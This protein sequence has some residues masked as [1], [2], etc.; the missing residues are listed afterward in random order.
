MV[1]FVYSVHLLANVAYG[2]LDL[3]GKNEIEGKKW[4]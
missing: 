1:R 2:S 3:C 4:R